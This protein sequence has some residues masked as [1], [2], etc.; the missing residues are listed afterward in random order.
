[1][2]QLELSE[3]EIQANSRADVFTK[4]IAVVQIF[5]LILSGIGRAVKPLPSSQLEILTLA[6]AIFAILIYAAYWKKPQGAEVPTTITVSQE[7]FKIL[8]AEIKSYFESAYDS[9]FILKE[10]R[11][12]LDSFLTDNTGDQEYLFATLAVATIFGSLHC[13]AWNFQ[14]PSRVELIMWRTA[15]LVCTVWPALL[16]VITLV[17][18][19]SDS[20]APSKSA[21]AFIKKTVGGIT[22]FLYAVSRISLIVIA[23]SSIRSIA[24][25]VYATTWAKNLPNVP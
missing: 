8:V 13:I 14:F 23:F 22:A 18:H 16:L 10:G 25:G 6:F 15:S 24:A 7:R 12:P 11:V 3:S 9:D 2:N 19:D 1:M 21:A 17:F 5:A 4:S 20:F